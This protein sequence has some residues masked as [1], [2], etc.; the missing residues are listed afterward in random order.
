MPSYVTG[1]YLAATRT[2]FSGTRTQ[3]S[4]SRTAIALFGVALGALEFMSTAARYIYAILFVVLAILHVIQGARHRDLSYRIAR[5][6]VYDENTKPRHD[7]KQP[8]PLPPGIF[9]PE[10][11]W[12]TNA[13]WIAL[14][15]SFMTMFAY[16]VVV[17]IYASV[18]ASAL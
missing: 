11:E 3:L 12:R 14:F 13:L 10:N 8:P 5:Q 15:V 16:F 9:I 2:C 4:Y 18:V 17:E 1:T 6:A 7:G